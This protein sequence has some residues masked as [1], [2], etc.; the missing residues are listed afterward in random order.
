MHLVTDLEIFIA[1]Y[2]V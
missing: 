2:T 1:L